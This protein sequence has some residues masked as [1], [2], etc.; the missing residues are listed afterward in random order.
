MSVRI[1]SILPGYLS[2]NGGP[3]FVCYHLLNAM[4]DAGHDIS[5]YCVTGDNNIH[6][7]FQ[8]LSM[9]LWAKP[10]GYKL[11]SQETWASY[12][13]WRYRH[14]LKQQDIAYIWN[15]TSI[16]TYKAVKAAGHIILTENVNTH[17]A[18]SK[19]ILDD[20]YRRLGLMPNHGIDVE[21]IAHENAQLE[22]V[23]YVFSPS[24]EVTKSLLSADI[25][26][27]KIIQTS[28][29]LG[30]HEILAPQD[31]FRRAKQKELT[32]I[33]VGRIGIRKG[34]HLL[35][36]Y[37]AKAGIKGKLKL[38][39]RI[40]PSA[41]HLIEPYLSRPDI[42]HIPF[43]HDL[44]SVYL[45]ADIFLF[46]SLEEGSPLV[47]YLALGAGLASIV[48]TMGGDGIIQHGKEGLIIDAHHA[49]EWIESIRKIFTDTE[50]RLNISN[51]AYNKS[52]EY[53]W[54]NVGRQRI[55]SL[56][57]LLTNNRIPKPGE[58]SHVRIA[59]VE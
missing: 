48:S 51:N 31:I 8:H 53:L 57:D 40:E 21:S 22:L 35:L 9:P 46:P 1:N 10:F 59:D 49:D 4:H 6:K 27:D 16:E 15:S 39:G 18:T 58:I 12:T 37:W 30:E 13:E 32:A 29:G 7:P 33:F 3:S 38:V 47:T 17:Q 55:A 25:P 42:E 41:K 14:A 24:R 2:S 23:D 19:R 20:E 26:A 44:R 45:D 5:L 34:V 11:F 50:Y 56:Q 54:D 28:Y 36:E 52:R 43:T